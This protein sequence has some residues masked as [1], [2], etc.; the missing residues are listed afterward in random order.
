MSVGRG[1][2][3]PVSGRRESLL[4]YE[5]PRSGRG[6]AAL[7]PLVSDLTLRRADA[8][9]VFHTDQCIR[10][11]FINIFA[12]LAVPFVYLRGGCAGV[13]NRYFYPDMFLAWL[14][15]SQCAAMLFLV[16]MSIVSTSAKGVPFAPTPFEVTS[17]TALYVCVAVGGRGRGAGGEEVGEGRG[18][19]GSGA[20]V[21]GDGDGGGGGCCCAGCVA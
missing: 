2:A 20:A 16:I 9:A 3:S 14:Q 5:G 18:G 1:S 13:R 12:F 21:E 10:E 4:L 7:P 6:G 8:E 15:Y 11:T 17:A 19:R